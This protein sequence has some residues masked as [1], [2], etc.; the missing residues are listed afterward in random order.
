MR[1]KFRGI[2]TKTKLSNICRTGDDLL[3]V[4]ID[5]HAIGSNIKPFILPP[6][7]VYGPGIDISVEK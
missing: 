3:S 4:E 1:T 5:S 7:S 6:R 2:E